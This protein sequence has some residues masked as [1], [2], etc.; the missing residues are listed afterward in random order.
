MIQG[1]RQLMSNYSKWNITKEE[2][3]HFTDTL[4]KALAPLRAKAEIS[5]GDLAKIIGVS[6]QNIFSN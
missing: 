5:Q 6:R 3:Q 2:Q 4:V 1:R